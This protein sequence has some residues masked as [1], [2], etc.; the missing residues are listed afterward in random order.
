MELFS[1]HGN[2]LDHGFKVFEYGH[3]THLVMKMGPRTKAKV[4]RLV[5]DA[6]STG[7]DIN[8]VVCRLLA[9]D[10]PFEE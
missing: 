7:A 5:D 2:D 4:E 9:A 6:R 8:E 10:L 1:T 3:Q